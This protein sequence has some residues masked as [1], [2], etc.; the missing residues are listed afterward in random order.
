MKIWITAAFLF[1]A[2][3]VEA[4]QKEGT[5][6]YERKINLHKTIA[7]P[8]MKA[9]MPEFRTTK[10][11]LLFS[12]SISV[13]Q[14]L[15]DDEAPDPFAGGDGGG[16]RG[17]SMRFGGIG[18]DAGTTYRNF[19]QAKVVQATELGG[20]NFLI[21]D[22]I[23]QQA[24]KMS[25]ETKKILGY[26]CFKASMKMPVRSQMSIR[27]MVSVN[28]S[29]PDST[30]TSTPSVPREADLV[31]WYAPAILTPAGPEGYGMLPGVI[32]EADFDNGQMAYKAL[33]VKSSVN[34]KEL[35]EP[36]KGKTVTR[37]EY[38][39][40]MMDLMNQQM[41]GMMRMNRSFQ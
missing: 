8:E 20:K 31:V 4:Q 13:Y 1:A 14:L 22:T 41:P 38:Q 10:H 37:A 5:I 19:A 7:N 34:A 21:V 18:G 15:P 9:Y 35:K 39:K 12:D 27:T 2:T 16:G 26:T 24:W 6:I 3:L 32:L 40:M 33:E 29:K 25:E 30:K 36:T 23:K 11:A 28:G 17:I